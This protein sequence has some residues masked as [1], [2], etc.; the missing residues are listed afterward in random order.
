MV[1]PT[2]ELRKPHIENDSS[3]SSKHAHMRPV[4][5]TSTASARSPPLGSKDRLTADGKVRTAEH[6][7]AME[8]LES[9]TGF[10]DYFSYAAIDTSL[11]HNPAYDPYP[12]PKVFRDVANNRHVV[13]SHCAII[14]L[15]KEE[16]SPS[17]A[18]LRCEKLSAV[19][20][21]Q[22]LRTPPKGVKVQIVLWSLS[23]GPTPFLD[24]DFLTVFGLGLKL[25]P[26]FFQHIADYRAGDA[27]PKY[28]GN[29]WSLPEYLFVDGTA[30][31]ICHDC[32]L[33]KP[34]GPPVLLIV[35]TRGLD[36]HIRK[37]NLYYSMRACA[38]NRVSQCSNPKEG[39]PRLFTQLLNASIARNTDSIN[40]AAALL[41]ESLLPLLQLN[42]L[43]MR[44]WSSH[45]RL[46]FRK[47]KAP[48][49]HPILDE[50]GSPWI[51]ERTSER[52]LDHTG[53]ARLYQYRV[54]LRSSIDSFDGLSEPLIRFIS[55]Q[56]APEVKASPS[57]HR[58]E[59]ERSLLVKE[60]YAL[61]AEIRDFLQLQ[62]SQ[63][64]LLES[65]KS[66]E[67]SNNQF[68]ENKRGK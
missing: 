64:S 34:D 33:A 63:L 1:S 40:D 55:S 5:T 8:Y 42:M 44:A 50:I 48:V 24:R 46:K 58:I 19:Q 61:E 60:A 22:S 4:S 47:Q 20:V 59:Q 7:Q 31:A 49:V 62:T 30:V 35:T 15:S 11:E 66:I 10:S 16:L 45:V 37:S 41:F 67:L 26:P 52:T 29:E 3:S 17:K 36:Y 13:Q 56:L 65:R 18:T 38:P 43:R 9:E 2:M 23:K 51:E 68:Q 6:A 25:N 14:D 28:D 32:P 27:S 54:F 57:Y 12:L 39:D 53:D 21:L